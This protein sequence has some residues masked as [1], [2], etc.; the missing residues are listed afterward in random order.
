MARSSLS[1]S[2]FDELVAA[3]AQE[4]LPHIPLSVV[5]VN[6]HR[7]LP[8]GFDNGNSAAKVA[9]PRDGK[10]HLARFPACVQPA[11]EVRAGAK[12][13]TYEL[14]GS[15]FWVGATAVKQ[16]GDPLRIGGT[17]TRF[18]DTRMTE[19]M[20]ATIVEAM[21]MAGYK[22]GTYPLALGMAIPNA[23]IA[24]IGEGS[25]ERLGVIADVRDV[26]IQ[27]IK[28]QV[29]SVIRTDPMG[30]SEPWIL[31]IVAVA[32]Q[33]QTAGTVLLYTKALNG[34][35]VTDLDSATVV[36]I[37]GGD[38][39]ITDVSFNPYQLFSMRPGPGTIRIARALADSFPGVTLNDVEA[40]H[41]LVTRRL[42]ASGR[43]R[44]VSSEVER[45]IMQKGSALLTEVLPA[46]QQTAK[47]V[48]ITGG[49]LLL[50]DAML[51]S[52]LTAENKREHEDY[53]MMPSAWASGANSIGALMGVFFLLR[54]Q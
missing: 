24:I 2:I 32:P 29:W 31:K 33:A 12:E 45:L 21:S 19:Y 27:K 22:P 44:D 52:M 35:T 49:G 39:Q 17:V 40:Q 8:I 5:A 3:A 11:K 23:E 41:V 46:I 26:L 36:D 54:S 25:T 48:I 14:N 30:K 34:T 4:R 51:R 50:L 42:L 10:I 13:T 1:R 18:Q 43:Y 7:A 15:R 20:A 37:G 38:L 53:I 6:G 47:F 16:R 28:D 9:I